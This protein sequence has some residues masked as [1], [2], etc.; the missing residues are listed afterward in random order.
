VKGYSGTLYA[1]YAKG[2]RRH[3]GTIFPRLICNKSLIGVVCVRG[4]L[5]GGLRYGR[6]LFQALE[7]LRSSRLAG[8]LT[9]W[10]QV[11]IGP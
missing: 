10:G 4:R 3:R 1:V 9:S 7:R 6:S 11:A 5:Q 2:N 8:L